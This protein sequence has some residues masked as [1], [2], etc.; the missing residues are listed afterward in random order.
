MKNGFQVS[1]YDINENLEIDF[2]SCIHRRT[3]DTAAI[4]FVNYFGFMQPREKVERLSGLGIMLIEDNTQSFLT[5]SVLFDAGNFRGWSFDSFR[6]MLPVADG[7]SLM[8]AG[9]HELT[10]VSLYGPPLAHLAAHWGGLILKKFALGLPRHYIESLRQNFFTL[11]VRTM[12]YTAPS[13]ISSLSRRMIRHMDIP[14]IRAKRRRNYITLLKNL[15]ENDFCRP[16]FRELPEGV[17]PF[18]MPIYAGNREALK[19]RLAREKIA[20]AVL[21]ENARQTAGAE[22]PVSRKISENIMVLPVGQAYSEKDML[23]ISQVINGG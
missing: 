14:D 7:A 16:V 15:K 8:A 2:E 19:K 20:G 1:F 6:K 4:L 5:G 17:C 23:R 9:A 11:S 13:G 21:W 22:N 10:G 12:D 3:R 18:G